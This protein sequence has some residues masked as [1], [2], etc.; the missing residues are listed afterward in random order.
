M[1]QS[2]VSDLN[3]NLKCA[4]RKH[5]STNKFITAEISQVIHEL[6]SWFMRYGKN[7]VTW[8]SLKLI[9]NL[10]CRV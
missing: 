7:H 2:E 8:L 6:D 9:R 1:F 5:L 4:T 3:N 10:V